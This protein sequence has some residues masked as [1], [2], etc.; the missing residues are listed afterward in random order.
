MTVRIAING[1]GRIGRNVLRALY[2]SNYR[3]M[4]QIVAINDLGDAP[5]IAHLLKYDTVHGHFNAEVSQNNNALIVN[6]D[7]ICLNQIR[8][9]EKLP[10]G[11]LKIDVV[12]ECTGLFTDRGKT[13]RHL[14]A[15]AK[16]V[17]V[18]A[19]GK[20]MDATIVFGVNFW[21]S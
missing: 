13:Q 10:W 4:L 5:T 9:P 3:D 1:F 6:G 15:G 14:D 16:K 2:E 8:N 7:Y 18:S 11:D 12:F 19:P 21:K 17:I 20:D